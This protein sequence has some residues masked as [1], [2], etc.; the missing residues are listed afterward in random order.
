MDNLVG[1]AASAGAGAAKSK[2]Y[3]SLNNLSFV[4]TAVVC[5]K[6]TDHNLNKHLEIVVCAAEKVEGT[7][8]YLGGYWPQTNV[9]ACS[10]AEDMRDVAGCSHGFETQHMMT[11][12]IFWV[13]L[14]SQVNKLSPM[15]PRIIG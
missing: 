10:L 7:Q 9:A 8:N 1:P 14:G 5:P 12:Y 4:A 15:F 3:K 6:G 13:D 11:A 2:H